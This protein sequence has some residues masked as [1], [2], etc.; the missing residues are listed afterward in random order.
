MAGSGAH[1]VHTAAHGLVA[2]EKHF[3]GTSRAVEGLQRLVEQLGAAQAGIAAHA[4]HLPA[5]H[6]VAQRALDS[7]STAVHSQ[8]QLVHVDQHGSSKPGTAAWADTC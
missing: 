5:A 8:A 6:E 3:A 4:A 1:A 2:Q 7:A